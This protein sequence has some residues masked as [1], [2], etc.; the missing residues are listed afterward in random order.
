MED[1]LAEVRAIADSD[2]PA[3]FENTI[4]ALERSG[5]V[6][7]RTRRVFWCLTS[8]DTDPEL[9]AIETEYA[10]R[11]SAHADAI[12]LDRA[13]FGRI[14]DLHTRR[15]QLGLDAESARL[16]DRYHLDFVR[17]G[18]ALAEADQDQLRALNAELATLSTQFGV[19]LLAA[20]KE[21]RCTSPT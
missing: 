15:D 17:A 7:D 12:T 1:Q 5:R 8:A 18:A 16:L 4:V 10:P 21:R 19:R 11:L 9:Q 14:D 20:A 6:L 3:T 13:L 2:V